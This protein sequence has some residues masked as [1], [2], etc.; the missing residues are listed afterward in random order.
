[1]REKEFKDG[2]AYR[3]WK[4]I[5]EPRAVAIR[6]LIAQLNRCCMTSLSCQRSNAWQERTDVQAFRQLHHT[7][8]QIDQAD[9][10]RTISIRQARASDD[11]YAVFGESTIVRQNERGCPGHACRF[12]A[13]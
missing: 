12:K 1:M 8:L 10:R 4:K 3:A 9:E 5:L 13:T 2:R 6:H 11:C 7:R